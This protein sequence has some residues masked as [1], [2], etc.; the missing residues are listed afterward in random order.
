MRRVLFDEN[1]PGRLKRDLPGFEILTVGE[2]GWNGVKNGELLRRAAA[3]FDCF[4]T[5][6]RSIPHQQTLFGLELGVVVLR[7]GTTKLDDLSR[8]A[9]QIAD[10]LSSVEYGQ[11]VFVRKS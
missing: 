4:L 5:A 1:L 11:V 2:V 3:E 9:A 6:D 10:A 8:F 7:L